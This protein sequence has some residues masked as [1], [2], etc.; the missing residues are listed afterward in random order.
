M[1]LINALF[2]GII[3]FDG[4]RLDRAGGISALEILRLRGYLTSD[5]ATRQSQNGAERRQGGNNDRDHDLDDE[6][7]FFGHSSLAVR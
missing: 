3:G 7:C 1:E 5:I 2:G 6:F 4:L